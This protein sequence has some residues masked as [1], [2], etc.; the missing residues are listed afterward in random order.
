MNGH[1]YGEETNYRY[2]EDDHQTQQAPTAETDDVF[3]PAPFRQGY[4]EIGN[5]DGE[6]DVDEEEARDNV[7]EDPP[8]ITVQ[9]EIKI[10]CAKEILLRDGTQL[11]VICVRG[12]QKAQTNTKLLKS[13]QVYFQQKVVMKTT[14][15]RAAGKTRYGKKPLT[16]K[17]LRAEDTSELGQAIID[18]AAY[19]K[20]LDRKLFS[21][22]LVKSQFPEASID[23]Y[24]TAMPVVGNGRSMSTRVAIG[25]DIATNSQVIQTTRNSASFNFNESNMLARKQAR[26]SE[27]KIQSGADQKMRSEE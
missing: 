7:E 2:D 26:G 18:L 14:L 11:K 16:L 25:H 1:E 24:L 3:I 22:E 23:F 6:S 13:S 19:T 12:E 4:A 10:L 9:F 17:L 20:C 5:E 15:E 21:V 27:L 8:L